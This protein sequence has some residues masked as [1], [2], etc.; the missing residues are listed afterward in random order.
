MSGISL[1]GC[2]RKKKPTEDL[3]TDSSGELT[4]DSTHSTSTLSISSAPKDTT[5]QQPDPDSEKKDNGMGLQPDGTVRGYVDAHTHWMSNVGFGGTLVCG[6]TFNEDGIAAALT[7]C[8]NHLPDGRAAL[9]ENLTHGGK[10][11]PFDAHDPVGWPT[12]KDWPSAD[13]KTHQQ[14]Y[15]KWV[16]RS[17]KAGQRI[18]VHHMVNNNVLCSVPAQINKHSCDDMINVRK[19]IAETRRLQ[20]FIDREHG[21]PGKGWFRIVTS[22]KHA[23]EV[24]AQGK[25]AVVLG[26]EVSAPFGCSYRHGAG[27]NCDQ[28]DIERGLDEM[29]DLGIRSMFLCHKFDNALCGVRFDGGT[30]GNMINVGNFLNTGAWWAVE[31][32]KTDAKD[33]TV[34]SVLMTDGLKLL[35]KGMGIKNVPAYGPGPHCNQRGMTKLGE[36]ALRG[37]MKRGMIVEVDH[38]SVKA[39]GRALSIMEEKN[40]AGAISSHSWMSPAYFERLYKLGGFVAQYG[41]DASQFVEEMKNTKPIREK[42]GG[43]YGF[44]MDMNGFG[45]TPH[46]PKDGEPT[47]AYPFQTKSKMM[48]NKLVTGKREWDYNQD[49]VAHYGMV[50]DWL[51]HI[52][53]L[54]G[55]EA[56]DELALASEKYLQMWG[57]LNALQGV[58]LAL[59]KTVKASSIEGEPDRPDAAAHLAVDGDQT[60]RWSSEWSEDQTFTV[61]LGDVL[62]FS[63]VIIDWEQASAKKYRLETSLDG[64]HWD[65]AIEVHE[66]GGARRDVHD[67]GPKL[68]RYL[69]FVGE[70]RSSIYGYSIFELAIR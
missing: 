21:G 15:Y 24:I 20:A 46:K 39:A 33:N 9:L 37:L 69:R 1:I 4:Q 3:P 58:N 50:P 26:V 55:Q 27:P 35:F 45:G 59:G 25:L 67:L 11:G 53:Q 41:H 12:F 23:R 49:G 8:H 29:Y 5:N 7:D 66:V 63:K 28:A 42:Y 19:Q 54:G 60:T 70:E 18:M 56:L 47:I 10:R 2:Q 17:W 14:M 31:D 65:L 51:E 68:T 22:P 36:Y 30:Q 40:Y 61:D 57:K 64:T 48:M 32:C 34:S 38:M 13:S 16:E 52:R 43:G 6:E 44:G 62:T